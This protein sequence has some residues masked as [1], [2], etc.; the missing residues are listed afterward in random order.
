MEGQDAHSRC[1]P[2]MTKNNTKAT[3]KSRP[4]DPDIRIYCVTP[5]MK[6]GGPGGICCYAKGKY[7]KVVLLK[8]SLYKVGKALGTYTNE[9]IAVV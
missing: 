8:K 6:R 2:C 7:I 3:K 5:G 9:A 4:A 1:G